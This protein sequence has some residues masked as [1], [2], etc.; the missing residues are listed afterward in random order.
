M[1]PHADDSDWLH[2]RGLYPA[3]YSATLF[4]LMLAFAYRLWS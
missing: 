3:F 4:A 2:L 1:P